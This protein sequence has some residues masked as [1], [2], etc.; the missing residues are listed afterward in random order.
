MPRFLLALLLAMPF[1]AA[2]SQ[3]ES[4]HPCSID[5]VA[6]GGYDLVSYHQSDGPMMGLTEIDVQYD[7]QTYLFANEDN[8]ELFLSN[9]SQYLPRYQGW[10][11]AT[12]AMGRLACPDYTNFKIEDGQLLLF[13]LVGFTNG[14]TLWNSDPLGF[15]T[16]ADAN[17]LELL[18]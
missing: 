1:T 11:A 15:R 4:T 18:D 8:R 14:R 7:H 16:R 17:A 6:I 5:G 3:A 10:C 12:L 9:P 2:N 13:E